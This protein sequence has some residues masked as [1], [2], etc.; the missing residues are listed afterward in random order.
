MVAN[1]PHPKSAYS[2]VRDELEEV[3]VRAQELKQQLLDAIDEDTWSFQ[4]LMEASRSGDGDRIRAATLH[5]AEVPL[6]VAEACVEIAGLCGRA[7]DL[8]LPASA[9]DAGVGAGMASAAALGAAMNVYINLHD[10]DDDPAAAS[11]LESA[12]AAVEATRAVADQVE[13]EVL[14]R[15]GRSG[16]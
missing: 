2:G 8:G 12:D 9:S 14:R 10:I 16:S 6:R 1:L 15:L 3:A 7:L 5:A 11:M 4:G 13:A